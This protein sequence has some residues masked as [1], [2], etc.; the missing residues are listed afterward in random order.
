MRDMDR[1]GDA[2]RLMRTPTPAAHEGG[3]EP[4][5]GIVAAGDLPQPVVRILG[6]KLEQ[7]GD[8]DARIAALKS[9][10]AGS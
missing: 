8:R 6:E 9:L 1:L 5:G 4:K 2:S 3:V 10:Q 7:F